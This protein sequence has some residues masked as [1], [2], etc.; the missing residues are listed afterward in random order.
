VR[1]RRLFG[2][3]VEHRVYKRHLR[4]GDVPHL[5]RL[6]PLSALERVLGRVLIIKA[7]KPLSAARTLPAAA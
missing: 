5:W 1:L 7:F 4:R 3:F 2:A 6:V